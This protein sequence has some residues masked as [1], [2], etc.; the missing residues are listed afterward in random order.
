VGGDGW[1]WVVVSANESI[2][3][4]SSSAINCPAAPSQVPDTMRI[5]IVLLNGKLMELDAERTD[6]VEVTLFKILARM[7]KH[8]YLALGN[9]DN[10]RLVVKVGT[11]CE[12]MMKGHYMQSIFETHTQP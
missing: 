2:C 3:A 8:G 1:W 5:W 7:Y 6:T 11:S 9:E 12:V 4:G 10:L